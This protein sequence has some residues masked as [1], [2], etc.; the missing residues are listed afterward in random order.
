MK[1]KFTFLKISLV[2]LFLMG[3]FIASGQTI[4]S[5]TDFPTHPSSI[6]GETL[7]VGKVFCLNDG[8]TIPATAIEGGDAVSYNWSRISGSDVSGSIESAGS[9]A[10]GVD[11]VDNPSAP[12]YYIY[13]VVGVNADG[14]ESPYAEIM[15]YLLPNI[16]IEIANNGA[17][18]Y[19][20]GTSP[21]TTI[22]AT[23]T[24]DPSV[25]EVF[26]YSIAWFKDGSQ[27]SGETGST[28]TLAAGDDYKGAY[29]A[30]A[31]F[32][33]EP[34]CSEGTS[35]TVT[36]EENTLPTKPVITF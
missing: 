18:E 15:V 27:I 29:T 28:L 1:G 30:T 33:I 8:I 11:F 9:T 36:I 13:R 16:S 17:T 34:T 14:C 31:K 19:C 21:G 22:T 25:S 23:P 6:D 20:I 4:S 3:G 26:A 35:N 5:L 24:T 12:G 10:N 7:I 2:G 32:E